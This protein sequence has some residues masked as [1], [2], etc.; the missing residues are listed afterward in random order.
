MEIS[1]GIFSLWM[2]LRC[3]HKKRIC[4]IDTQYANGNSFAVGRALVCV[5]NIEFFFCC[6]FWT[7]ITHFVSIAMACPTEL[8]IYG[9]FKVSRKSDNTIV[10][11]QLFIHNCFENL[12]SCDMFSVLFKVYRFAF[13]S[14][15]QCF[16]V[17]VKIWNS[18]EMRLNH[19]LLRS[20]FNKETF[21]DIE[22]FRTI[23]L[24][25]YTFCST[26]LL[27]VYAIQS[28]WKIESVQIMYLH[29]RCVTLICLRLTNFMIDMPL[30][31]QNLLFGMKFNI[32]FFLR[33]KHQINDFLHS[34]IFIIMKC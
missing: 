26:R 9:T 24:L 28:I 30:F 27:Y 16:S 22:S 32:F 21:C 15:V 12:K 18:D 2:N 3:R 11:R 19:C 10:Q 5:S 20:F 13:A 17:V 4:L 31:E 1:G 8:Y 6:C 29:K 33:Y 23:L 7:R 34:F 25:M 14:N